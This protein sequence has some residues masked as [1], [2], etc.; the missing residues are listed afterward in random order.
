MGGDIW[1]VSADTVRELARALPL[2]GADAVFLAC[3]NLPTYDV[4][5]ALEAELGHAG[6]V[7]QPGDD[8]GGAARLGC[9]APSDFARAE[10]PLALPC[11]RSG[12]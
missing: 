5:P 12:A 3:T 2:D 1:R 8:V 10:R 7:G 9:E 4:I 6:A 11:A